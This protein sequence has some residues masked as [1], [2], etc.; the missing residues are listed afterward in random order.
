MLKNT[1][2]V[3]NYVALILKSQ[4]LTRIL[5]SDT[6]RTI[7]GCGSTTASSPLPF[8][9]AMRKRARRP[10][11]HWL[12]LPKVHAANPQLTGSPTPG[13]DARAVP[14]CQPRGARTQC[15]PE[16]PLPSS[17]PPALLRCVTQPPL[18]HS[19]GI[20]GVGNRWGT[21]GVAV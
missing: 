10:V 8:L 15:S 6:N 13:A 20:Y 5:S 11:V 4:T 16:S 9:T 19:A 17:L 18:P 12:A 21:L 2:G 7:A 1:P 14:A 3:T